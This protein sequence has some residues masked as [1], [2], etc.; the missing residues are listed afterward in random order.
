MFPTIRGLWTGCICFLILCVF[1]SAADAGVY[2]LYIGTYDR[3]DSRGIFAADVNSLLG[4][5]SPA[6]NVA[7]VSSPAYLTF[8]QD[9][10][11]LYAAGELWDSNVYAFQVNGPWRPVDGEEDGEAADEL[12]L[13]KT[14]TE[15]GRCA[16]H[17]QLDIPEQNLLVSNYCGGDVILLPLDKDRLPGEVSQRVQLEGKSVHARQEAPHPHSINVYRGT[18]ENF[19]V[20]NE[21]FYVP[22]LGTDKIMI[23]QMEFQKHAFRAAVPESASVEPGSGPRHMTFHNKLPRA[24]VLNELAN[25]V[26]VFRVLEDGGLEA[27][28]TISTLPGDFRESGKDSTSAAIKLHPSGDFLYTSNRGHDCITVFQIAAD[29]ELAFSGTVPTGGKTPRDFAI[30]PDGECLLAANQD[31]GNIVVFHL[32]PGTG[33]LTPSGKEIAVAAPVCL[34]F[35]PTDMTENPLAEEIAARPSYPW[36]E[37]MKNL[38]KMTEDEVFTE[39]LRAR[40]NTKTVD[41]LMRIIALCESALEK[42]M[43]GENKTWAEDILYSSV[44]LWTEAVLAKLETLPAADLAR[45]EPMTESIQRKLTQILE[46]QP[47]SV[48]ANLALAKILQMRLGVEEIQA[49]RLKKSGNEEKIKMFTQTALACLNRVVTKLEKS[50]E[51]ENARVSLAQAYATR[52]KLKAS[53]EPDAALA[54][55][56][57]AAELNPAESERYLHAR[58]EILLSE[59]RYE[60]AGKIIDDLIQKTAQ[61]G[62][63]ETAA[64][65]KRLKVVFLMDQK[66]YDEALKVIREVLAEKP[67]EEEFLQLETRML[68]MLK[69]YEELLPVLGKLIDKNALDSGLYVLRG[70]TFYSLDRYEEAL[71][72]FEKAAVLSAGNKETLSMKWMAMTKTGKTDDAIKEVRN[73]LKMD[74]NNFPL[75]LQEVELYLQAKRYKEVM[76]LLGEMEKK[77]LNEETSIKPG[78]P[79]VNPKTVGVPADDDDLPGLSEEDVRQLTKKTA[80]DARKNYAGT[81]YTLRA[82]V[83]LQ[84]GMHA[85]AA[86][87]YEKAVTASPENSLALNNLAWLYATSPEAAV[88]NGV[89]AVELATKAC[90]LTDFEEAGYLSTLGAA[91]AERGDFQNAMK[92]VQKGLEC[93]GDDTDVRD[94]LEK[95]KK[96]YEEKKPVREKEEKADLGFLK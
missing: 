78:K 5:I 41:D 68:V 32:N 61:D 65:L 76:T 56:D 1:I 80:S 19:A 24:Y 15:V 35:Q 26:S 17:L 67:E 6:E 89:R 10:K 58:L 28:Q 38:A 82:S 13:M 79:A 11:F 69:R 54:D 72:D 88:R 42:G 34:V 29:G 22:D 74:P 50:P 33:K 18:T 39:I 12:I 46:F 21:F 53:E 62:D 3:D 51:D 63:A 30:S 86:A 59:E 14:V 60:A 9:Y 44:M 81:F 66:L 43:T 27:V 40:T 16:C 90:E 71:K 84:G 94:S 7:E 25:T 92:W 36:N 45:W 85:A 57:K 37:T 49:E 95:E 20:S 75:A 70:T 73:L 8:S 96:H 91:Y 31:T 52:A 4:D 47:D 93:C 87:D 64:E 48:E 23:Y 2:R 55:L 83:Y 77:F